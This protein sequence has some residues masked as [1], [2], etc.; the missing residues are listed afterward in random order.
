MI[1]ARAIKSKRLKFLT[2]NKVDSYKKAGVTHLLFFID[3]TNGREDTQHR[4]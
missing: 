4:K 1:F 2:A 3:T